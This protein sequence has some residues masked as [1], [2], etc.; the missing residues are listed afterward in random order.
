MTSKDAARALAAMGYSDVRDFD[1]GKE[2]WTAAGLPL[3][4]S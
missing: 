3:E 1:G 4:K 2:A